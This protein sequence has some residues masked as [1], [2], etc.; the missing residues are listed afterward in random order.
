MFKS[1]SK[2]HYNKRRTSKANK[3]QG[4]KSHTRNKPKKVKVVLRKKKKKSS[5]KKS[6][7]KGKGTKLKKRKSSKSGM[8]G[9]QYLMIPGFNFD[10]LLINDPN[11]SSVNAVDVKGINTKNMIAKL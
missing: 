6:S 9:G 3:K 7:K 8:K 1:R 10:D 2:K 11:N 5:K 4:V